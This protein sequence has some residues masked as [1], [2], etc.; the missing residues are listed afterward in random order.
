MCKLQRMD[1]DVRNSFVWVGAG[2]R[3]LKLKL[4][5]AARERGLSVGPNPVTNPRVGGMVPTSGSGVPTLKYD[6]TT[7]ENIRALRMVTL[8]GNAMETRRM[9]L[10]PS[11]RRELMQLYCG[12][13]DTLGVVCE[14]ATFNSTQSAVNAMVALK[15]QGAP[16]TLLRRES[17]NE[18][19]METANKCSK[20]LLPVMATVLLEFPHSDASLRR[21]RADFKILLSIFRASG[22]RVLR[23]FPE[24]CSL[25]GR[26][27]EGAAWLPLRCHALLGE[28]GA[29]ACDR[30]LCSVSG[31]AC[32]GSGD[33]RPTLRRTTSV[34][35]F[36]LASATAT[37]HLS[38]P[39]KD[40]T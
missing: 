21:I 34:A 22:R 2:A 35:S 37:F 4:M 23:A 10:E 20:L 25:G 26:R 16:T 14:V 38:V 8:Q 36:V 28:V 18:R 1:S 9:M 12:G 6:G 40:K 19:A 24:G 13:E 15:R 27:V 7:R 32:R 33:G 29:D 39:F 3:K 11:L 31:V 30:R 5:K 17:L